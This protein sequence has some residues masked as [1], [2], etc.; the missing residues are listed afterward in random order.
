M[1]VM[2]APLPVIGL[3]CALDEREFKLRRAYIRAVTEAGGAPILLPAPLTNDD[4]TCRA[5][6][7]AQLDACAAI[8][9]TG[10]PDPDMRPFG[11]PNH[12]RASIMDP[13]RQAHERAL[14]GLLEDRPATPTLGICLGMQMMALHAGGRLEQHLPDVLAS[15]PD[16]SDDRVHAV[17][18]AGEHAL[19]TAGSVTSFHHQGVRDAGRLRVAARAHDGVIEAI[20]DPARRFY[21]G[22]QWHPERTA[23]R[24]LGE[25]L[26]RALVEAA[27]ARRVPG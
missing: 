18:P 11:E 16:H 3:T 19:L 7:R 20:D 24:A 2:D 12:P 1:G 27:G 22:V 14:L 17:S 5:V 25:R 21:L 9:L 8:I 6:A 26:F 15:A 23:D 10:G 4:A 13:F